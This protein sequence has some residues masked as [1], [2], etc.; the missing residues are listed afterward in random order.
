MT[1]DAVNK[2]VIR[3]LHAVTGVVE[4]VGTGGI[5]QG[6]RIGR[7]AVAAHE[8]PNHRL[9][10]QL[11]AVRVHIEAVIAAV[12]VGHSQRHGIPLIPRQVAP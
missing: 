6:V 1:H 4:Q 11:R 9:R 3:F 12:A 2:D 7:A 10:R 8:L 5:I